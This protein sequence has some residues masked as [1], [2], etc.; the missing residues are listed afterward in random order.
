MVYSFVLLAFTFTA[1]SRGHNVW[2]QSVKDANFFAPSVDAG[3]TPAQQMAHQYPAN[4]VPQQQMY[5]MPNMQ[6]PTQGVPFQGSP[7]QSS[8]QPLSMQGPQGYFPQQSQAP[9]SIFQTTPSDQ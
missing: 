6:Q 7:L 9:M 5:S 8:P 4:F 1:R 2:F 3:K